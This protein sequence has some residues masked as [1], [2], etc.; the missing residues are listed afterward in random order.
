MLRS[1]MS[2]SSAA[3]RLVDYG[4]VVRSA[5]VKVIDIPTRHPTL[6]KLR[7]SCGSHSVMAL[8][9][10]APS[11]ASRQGSQGHPTVLAKPATSVMPVIGRRATIP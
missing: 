5:G 6:R 2:H 4:M 9:E 11:C 7:D 1:G 10:V 8:V 3:H